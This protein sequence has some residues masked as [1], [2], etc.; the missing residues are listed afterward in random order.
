MPSGN[1]QSESDNFLRNLDYDE[2][3][4]LPCNN[5]PR[6][7]AD[8]IWDVTSTKALTGM[9]LF[10]WNIK[11]VAK[12]LSLDDNRF[13]ID[14]VTRDVWSKLQ[15][16][17]RQRFESLATETNLINQKKRQNN[18]D[19]LNRIAQISSLQEGSNSLVNGFYN[20]TDFGNDNP[21]LFL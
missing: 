1:F 5:N 2:I 3:C 8:R 13:L 16:F 6:M 9:D 14:L 15:N 11:L 21:V 17:Q 19:T 12:R 4:I 7:V 10:K 18:E 20:G